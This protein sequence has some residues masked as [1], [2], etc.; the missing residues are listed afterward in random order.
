M[1]PGKH[2]ELN[3]GWR[4]LY[5]AGEEKM[6]FFEVG[7]RK[8]KCKI[9][10]LIICVLTRK[11]Y[12]IKAEILNWNIKE[13]NHKSVHYLQRYGRSMAGIKKSG[14]LFFAP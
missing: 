2:L 8:N 12:H 4:L 14:V 5:K 3:L 9:L 1:F 7:V 13:E 10:S 11:W 6:A